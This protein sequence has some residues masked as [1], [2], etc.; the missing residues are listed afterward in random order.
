MVLDGRLVM[1]DPVSPD[2]KA[3]MMS[4]TPREKQH[5]FTLEGRGYGALGEEVLFTP[6][7]DGRA[8]SCVIGGNPFERVR[9]DVPLTTS[10]RKD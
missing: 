1:V 10:S 8:K 7:D 2:P 9:Y 6:G 4:L 5:S 3:G